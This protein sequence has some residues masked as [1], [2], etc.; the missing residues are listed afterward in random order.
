MRVIVTGDFA[1]IN[2]VASLIKLK[3]FESIYNNIRPILLNSDL[4]ITNLETP[5]TTSETRIEKTGPSLK[6]DK[7]SAE[8]IKYGGFSLVTLAN[9]HI[10]DYGE[11]GLNDT[12]STLNE[13]GIAYVGAGKNNTDARKPFVFKKDD[14]TLSVIAIAENEWSTTY[15]DRPGANPINEVDNYHDIFYAKKNY[16]YVL[17]IVHCGMEYYQL[18]SPQIK[19]L[20]HFFIDIGAD[21]VV[22]HHTHCFSGYEIYN[23]KPI[24]YGLGNFIFDNPKKSGN[25]NEGMIAILDFVDK[26]T[27]LKLIPYKQ[28]DQLT[29][30]RLLDRTQKKIFD[31][32]INKLNTII[33]DDD[34]LAEE[35]KK[36]LLLVKRQ[37]LWYLQ[38]FSSK[39]LRALEKWGLLP[40]ALL[41][42][43]HRLLLLNIIRCESHRDVLLHILK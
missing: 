36:Q 33:T 17:V 38:P 12:I 34:K 39:I 25:W 3:D 22:C 41:K 21:A 4:A 5:L 35:Y 18:P 7:E 43:S 32:E 26:N 14:K 29:G 1:P 8:A 40:E 27:M 10:L 16:D 6:A 15:N 37:Y 11:K 42:K 24:A 2:R 23:G 20:L 9:N 13:T 31:D 30:I 19:K 28:N